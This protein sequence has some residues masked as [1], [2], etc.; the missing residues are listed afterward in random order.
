M[1]S[2]QNAVLA[3]LKR[4]Q[5]FLDEYAAVL[6]AIVD[7]TA[8]RKRLDTVAASFTDHAYSASCHARRP[9]HRVAERLAADSTPTFL[10]YWFSGNRS[11]S[12]R[13]PP[14]VTVVTGRASFV[15]A[16][17]ESRPDR[18]IRARILGTIAPP[19]SSLTAPDA[20]LGFAR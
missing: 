17:L 4:V 11:L 13:V 12:K 9:A 1:K 19:V 20:A 15:H 14:G 5:L 7:L 8:A 6:A 10:L 2:L 18:G 16:P 3:A